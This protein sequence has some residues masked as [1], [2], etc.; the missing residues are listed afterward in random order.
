MDLLADRL[1][2]RLRLGGREPGELLRDLHVL[3][4]VDADRVRLSG[5][6]L[7]ARVGEGHLLAPC[8]PRRVHRDV[9]HR[10]GPVEGDERDQVLELRRLHGAQRLAHA[11][12]LE[13]E[14]AGRVAAREHRVRLRIVERKRADVDAADELDRLVDDV[15]VAQP[16]EVHLEEAEVDDVVHPDLRHHLRVGALLLER[17]DLDE[18]L[19][20][21]DDARRVDRVGA[22][23]PLERPREVDDLLRDRIGVDRLPELGA[24]LQRSLERLSG[25]FGHELRDAVDDAVRDVEH[26]PRVADRSAGSHGREGDDLRD[27]V[28]AVLLGDVVDDAI[29]ARDREVDVHVGQVLAGRVEEALEEEAV[30][31]RVDVRDLE[32]VRGDRPGRRAAT[33]AD[34]HAVLLREVD[35]V[36]DDEEVVREPHLLDRL[37]LEPEP[38][39]QLGG[40]RPVATSEALLAELDEVVEGVPAL[41]HRERRQQDPPEL[42]LDVAALRHLERARHRVLETGEVAR[43]LLGRLEEELVRVEAPVRRVLERVAG[44]DAE[45]RLVR[46]RVLGVEV[47]DVSGRDERKPGLLCEGDQLRV[48]LVL[49][50]EPGV[51]DLDVRRVAA[52]DL[53]EAVEIAGRV[54][55]AALRERAGDAARKAARERDDPLRVALEELPVDARLVVVALEVAE[56]RELDEVRVALV[57]L[58]QQGQ[59]GVPLRLR[60]AVVGDVDLAADDRL[61]ADLPRLPEELHRA[62]E[63]AVV[64]E[65]DGGHLEA[66]RLLHEIRDPARPVEDR[67]L[68]VDVQVDEGR[69]GHGMATLLTAADGSRQ[70]DVRA[71]TQPRRTRAGRRGTARCPGDR[72]A[73]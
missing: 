39:G 52:E 57:R 26:A 61:H 29:A 11:R 5:D 4:L 21:D 1:A 51:L 15:E 45:E 66:R 60:V 65:R 53:D 40:H 64:G 47:V 34:A 72:H 2:Q 58:G 17:D 23:Q 19:R 32:A 24:R 43:H 70:D 63:R 55:R 16:E 6:G 7:E 22:R 31:H 36:P 10:P 62:R 67:V 9:A 13:L 30:A 28:A 42:E 8:L 44:L 14:H 20:A 48:D 33:R 71:F 37:E 56:R 27:A 73:R 41:G 35:E 54:L 68:R 69:S 50:G 25:A 49:L 59:V 12:R 46:E 38:L 3:L 18:R